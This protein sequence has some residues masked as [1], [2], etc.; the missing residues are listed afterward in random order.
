[1]QLNQLT[2]KV[3]NLVRSI[4]FYQSIGLRLIV[5]SGNPYARL[6]C[7]AG[8][9]TLS[10]SV[11]DSVTPGETG[12]YFEVDDVAA[13]V[14]ALTDQGIVFDTPIKDQ[15]WLWTEAWFRDPDGHRLCLYYAGVNRRFAPWRVEG[16]Q[17][18]S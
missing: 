18:D 7:P 10:L 8:G 13:R 14:A 2:L 9:T 5:N 3:T 16:T 11:V 15:S 17:T 1:M 4:E 12:L 6:E